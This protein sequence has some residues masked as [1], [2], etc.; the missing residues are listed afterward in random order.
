MQNLSTE[1]AI[2]PASST[3]GSL[4]PA[5]PSIAPKSGYLP[6]LDGWRALA[7]LMVL[8]NH[9]LPWQIGAWNTAALQ[10]YGGW[11]VYLFF[12]ISGVLICG[13]ILD[14]EAKSGRIDLRAFY[15]RRLFRI[16]PA[17]FAYLLAI[18]LLMLA[19]ALHEHWDTWTSA[20]LLYNNFLWHAD[21]PAAG[22]SFVG[23]FWTLAVEEHFYLL[24][25]LLLFRFRRHRIALFATFIAALML[26]QKIA[27][28]LGHFDVFVSSRRT[29]WVLQFLLFPALVALL[30]RLPTVR[31]AAQRL[32]HPWL[33]FVAT[34]A[35]MAATRLLANHGRLLP[36]SDFLLHEHG[37]LFFGFTF[38]IVATMLHPASLTTRL[39]E[40]PLLRLLG[41]LSYSLY[42]WHVLFFLPA[43]PDLHITAPAL[44]SLSTRPSKYLATAAAAL[45]SYYLLERPMM[46]LGHRLAP[47][48][49]PG[50]HDLNVGPAKA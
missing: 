3:R 36:F 46:R 32:L 35:L 48:A 33:A 5:F 19:G 23:H 2:A 42:L 13:R 4:E 47:P 45:L 20:L 38:W 43:H 29:Y 8:V 39:L 37:L 40:L 30:L 22:A 24:L 17:V 15:T 49:T 50:H 16:Q 21:G 34:F 41:R 7:I 14:D 11:G 31:A 18:A 12:T 10:P 26:G 1:S 25:S 44:L 9:D 28:H 27:A 6:S